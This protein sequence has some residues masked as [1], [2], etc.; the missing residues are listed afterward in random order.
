MKNPFLFQFPE[1]KDLRVVVIR[2]ETGEIVVRTVEELERMKEQGIKF[3][4]L[5]EEA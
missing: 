4:V 3:E 5:K 2:L 1:A